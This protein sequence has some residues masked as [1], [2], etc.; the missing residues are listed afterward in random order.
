[1]YM[2]EK[3]Q[4]KRWRCLSSGCNP[5]LNEEEAISHNAESGHRVAKWPVRSEAG[6]QKARKRNKTG[7]Y[8]KYNVGDKSYVN[9]V[10]NG[11]MADSLGL[12]G[13]SS[14]SGGGSVS[15]ES[16]DEGHGQW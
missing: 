3:N 13:D 7:Y 15:M 14:Y 5:V 4:A 2:S 9:R 6:K 1:M 10:G 16:G 8:S 11:F 12:L